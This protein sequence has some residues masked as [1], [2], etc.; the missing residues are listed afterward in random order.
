M[1]QKKSWPA[2]LGACFVIGIL[3]GTIAGCKSQSSIASTR[4]GKSAAGEGDSATHID[5]LCVG[6][7]INSPSGRF[8][9]SYKYSDEANSI[10]NE[11][12]ITPQ[13]MDITSTDKS[14]TH[15]YHGVHSDEASW[16]AAVLDLSSLRFT[17]M[18]ARIDS[19]NGTS[20]IVSQGAEPINGYDTKKYSIDTTKANSADQQ[21]FQTL[22]GAGSFEKGTVWVPADGCA[23]KL[24]LDEAIVQTNGSIN[25]GRYE[26]ALTKK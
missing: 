1:R 8:H 16:N 22:F 19:L 10:D 21:Q 12:E 4:D 6:D 13:K 11:A 14:G 9:Y 5:L 26:L 25:K 7:R 23:V 20:A 2:K 3:S 17:G 15:S 18:T 24:I